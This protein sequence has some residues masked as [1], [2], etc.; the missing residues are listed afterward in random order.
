MVLKWRVLWMVMLGT[1]FI[2]G[3]TAAVTERKWAD[4]SNNATVCDGR[5]TYAPP[6]NLALYSEMDDSTYLQTLS[7]DWHVISTINFFEKSWSCFRGTLRVDNS[8]G[9]IVADWSFRVPLKDTPFAMTDRLCLTP[10]ARREKFTLTSISMPDWLR[11]ITAEDNRVVETLEIAK[12]S[13]SHSDVV[14]W[15]VLFDCGNWLTPSGELF[16]LSRTENVTPNTMD[17]VRAAVKR[18]G[19]NDF[20]VLGKC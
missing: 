16:F 1:G 14:D 9:C 3:S 13:G 6:S 15:V 5:K 19:V 8:T 4:V 17:Y 18:N 20:S 12:P 11:K 7:G 10:N 2:L